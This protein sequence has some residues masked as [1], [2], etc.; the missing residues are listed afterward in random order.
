MLQK[1]FGQDIE[2]SSIAERIFRGKYT[3]QAGTLK[4]ALAKFSLTRE[5]PSVRDSYTCE[6]LDDELRQDAVFYFPARDEYV[7]IRKVHQ[8]DDYETWGVKQNVSSDRIR[9]VLS[10]KKQSLTLVFRPS[11]VPVQ[12]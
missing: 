3:G 6:W 2:L 10:Q 5:T 9:E 12:A 8:S 4:K 1:N 7:V 11:P